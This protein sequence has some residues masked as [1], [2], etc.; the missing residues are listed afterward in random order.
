LIF[1]INNTLQKV[2]FANGK[3]ACSIVALS[4]EIS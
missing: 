2:V 3:D 4:Y 1:S